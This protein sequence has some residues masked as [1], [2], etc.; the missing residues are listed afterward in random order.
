MNGCGLPDCGWAKEPA[1]AS[2]VRGLG[3]KKGHIVL[4]SVLNLIEESDH[5]RRVLNALLVM[6]ERR[7]SNRHVVG[8]VKRLMTAT[9]REGLDPVVERCCIHSTFIQ[10]LEFDHYN[11]AL[12]TMG[13]AQPMS[14]F[15]SLINYHDWKTYQYPNLRDSWSR[16][17]LPAPESEGGVKLLF[18]GA[19]KAY[20]NQLEVIV[21]TTTIS[22]YTALRSVDLRTDQPLSQSE[23]STRSEG[24]DNS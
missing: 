17:T 11:R 10:T 18:C 19:G 22:E 5:Y 6:K 15:S 13:V 7:S 24:G 2:L 4:I 3:R 20:Q 1:A 8:S 16:N 23:N 21:C 14:D 12:N 9:L